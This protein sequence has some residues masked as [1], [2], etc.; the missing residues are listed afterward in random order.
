MLIFLLLS[1]E[2]LYHITKKTNLLLKELWYIYIYIHT[3]IQGQEDNNIK[4]KY[5]PILL[6]PLPFELKPQTLI[7]VIL[8]NKNK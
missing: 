5:T 2:L 1:L 8:Y 4:P 3:P 6:I 7:L